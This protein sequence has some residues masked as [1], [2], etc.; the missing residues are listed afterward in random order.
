MAELKLAAK[1]RTL[2]GRKVKRIRAEGWVPVIIYGQGQEPIP[3]QVPSLEFE[4]LLRSGATAQL[5]ELEVEGVG[6]KNVLVREVQRHPVRHNLLH[7]DF[8]AVSM[9]EKQ[10]VTVPVVA[11]GEVKGL[12]ADAVLVQAMDHVEI[13]ALP[14]NIP[15]QI[16]VDVTNLTPE[17]PITVADLPEL[18]GVEYLTPAE[19]TVF[20]L[21]MSRAAAAEVGEEEAE[22]EGVAEGGAEPEVISRGKQEE[23]DEE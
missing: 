8:Y 7:A 11:V 21:V 19:E 23:E 17:H 4:K 16:E 10:E 13:E 6:R 12:G 1:P 20:S 22:L 2:T 15:A 5:V 3:A 9:R 14:A 18:P